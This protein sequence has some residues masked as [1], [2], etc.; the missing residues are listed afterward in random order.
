[1]SLKVDLD[2]NQ[3]IQPTLPIAPIAPISNAASFSSQEV[4]TI[5]PAAHRE[6]RP[7]NLAPKL[8]KPKQQHYMLS[9]IRAHQKLETISGKQT[10]LFE[11]QIKMDLAEIERFEKEKDEKIRESAKFQASQSTWGALSSVAQYIMAGSS[12]AFGIASIASGGGAAIGS[13]L[14]A[15]G[16]VGLSSKALHDSGAFDSM[17]SWFT[18]SQEMR[19][20][21]ASRIEMGFFMLSFG[22]GLAGGIL[23][24]QTQAF[25]SQ[26]TLETVRKIAAS[27]GLGAS[28]GKGFID[29]RIGFLKR[30]TAV[31]EASIQ[32]KK[33]KIQELYQSIQQ[34]NKESQNMI[35]TTQDIAD[36]LK[37]AISISNVV[38]E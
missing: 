38:N 9:L 36:I 29:L 33:D 7:V 24:Y 18:K 1:M 28:V 26:E 34:E 3:Y 5:A 32:E 20:K 11:N 13:L 2:D 37:D 30:K 6:P 21:I 12:I 27:V 16:V 19:E 31:L 17:A 25:A 23:S 35:R 15:S 14:I 10:S 8:E 22:L 4:S